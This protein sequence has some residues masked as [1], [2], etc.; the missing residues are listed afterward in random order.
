MTLNL[1]SSVA[2]PNL[3]YLSDIVSSQ[4]DADRMDYLLRDS[5]F[6]GVSYGEFEIDW[7]M[8]S[9]ELQEIMA[10]GAT[11]PRI[12]VNI[13]GISALEHFVM[14]RRLMSR[15]VY[16]HPHTLAADHILIEFLCALAQALLDINDVE[17]ELL[18]V[19]QTIQRTHLGQLLY[20]L[21]TDKADGEEFAEKYFQ[22]YRDL[23]DHDIT[24]A[25]RLFTHLDTEHDVCE[26]AK[27]LFHRK[28]S[29]LHPS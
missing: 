26:L 20:A 12:C 3:A 27:R 10:D 28:Y 14:A 16:T 17:G 7:L 4:L 21:K 24:H 23:V 8:N 5:H 15:Y 22:S 25:M 2:T 6:C 9:L 19:L 13:K 29:Q 11:S 1:S 18:Q